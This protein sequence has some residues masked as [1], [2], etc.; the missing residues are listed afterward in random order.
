M[1]SE[2]S[3]TR[4]LSGVKREDHDAVH[5]LWERYFPRLARLA[6]KKLGGM[7]RGG[8]EGEDVALSAFH[9]FCRG[10]GQSRFPRLDAR[11]D[12]WQLLVV[13]TGRKAANLIKKEGRQKRGGGWARRDL[14]LEFAAVISREPDPRF[15]AAM[16]EQ[17][18]RLL[19]RLGDDT[20]RRIAEWKIEGRTNQEIAG[21]LGR[22]VG[23]VERKLSLIR[24][25]WEEGAP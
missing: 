21:L 10:A 23:W 6:H 20:L 2:G 11:D 1:S 13:I 8:E 4:L 18:R 3:V 24:V 25:K 7:D 14:D 15:A 9:S 16:D 17:Y 5:Q 12:L 19:D 22:S